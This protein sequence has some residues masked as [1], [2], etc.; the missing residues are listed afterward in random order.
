MDA[1]AFLRA[2]DDLMWEAILAMSP[3]EIDALLREGGYDP[4]AVAARMQACADR[5]LG[6]TT[7]GEA[8][9]G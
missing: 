9:D 5:I 4:Q 6:K 2:M 1:G 8:A 7:P 3:A